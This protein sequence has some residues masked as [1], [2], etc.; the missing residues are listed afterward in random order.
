[1]ILLILSIAVIVLFLIGVV[2]LAINDTSCR[3]TLAIG[4]IVGIL[5]YLFYSS[6]FYILHYFN[7]IPLSR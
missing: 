6:G 7:I 1:M 3:E 4:C 2:W 5:V